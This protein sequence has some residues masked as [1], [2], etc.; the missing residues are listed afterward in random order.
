MMESLDINRNIN[1]NLIWRIMEK[2][3]IYKYDKEYNSDI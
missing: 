3:W 1:Q 2:M